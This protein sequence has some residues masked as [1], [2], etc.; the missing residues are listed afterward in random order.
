MDVAL[1]RSGRDNLAQRRRH[2]LVQRR[3]QCDQ[4]RQALGIAVQR[5]HHHIHVIVAVKMTLEHERPPK[6]QQPLPAL[7]AAATERSTFI[8]HH[9]SDNRPKSIEIAQGAACR[10]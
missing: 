1:P 9:G 2:V 4:N 6:T 3:S 10:A 5:G 7:L 8:L